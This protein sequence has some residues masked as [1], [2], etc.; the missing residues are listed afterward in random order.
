MAGVA[1]KAKSTKS[2][3][4]ARSFCRLV[5]VPALAL[6][7]AVFFLICKNASRQMRNFCI[8]AV[9]PHACRVGIDRTLPHL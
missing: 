7:R 5:A 1:C 8:L 6:N 2:K 4:P 9:Q 3:K